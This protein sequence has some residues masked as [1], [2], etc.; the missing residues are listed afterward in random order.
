MIIGKC[1]PWGKWGQRCKVHCNLQS[2]AAEENIALC[3]MRILAFHW[4]FLRI[5]KA[6][7]SDY[8]SQN[9]TQFYKVIFCMNLIVIVFSGN[10]TRVYTQGQQCFILFGHT[11]RAVPYF[12]R[13]YPYPPSIC[14]INTPL[15]LQFAFLDFNRKYII[16]N[17]L[18][19]LNRTRAWHFISFAV[20]FHFLFY[21]IKWQV[22]KKLYTFMMCF[23]YIDKH[24]GKKQHW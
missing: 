18:D 4:T 23:Y 24:T 14:V 13:S 15:L 19:T 5:N 8:L 12:E 2:S 9:Q 16:E 22:V 17:I 6:F 21:F 20:L 7:F 11:L 10:V 3:A 1:Y